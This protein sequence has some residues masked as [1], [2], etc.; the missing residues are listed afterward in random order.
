[1]AKRCMYKVP[2][3]AVSAWVEECLTRGWV[4]FG[5]FARQWVNRTKF[6]RA[7]EFEKR[8]LDVLW[9]VD[10][11]LLKPEPMDEGTY[12]SLEED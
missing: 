11:G 9:Q 1:M 12:Q 10:R 2:S 3:G 6:K 8:A 5:S 7:L 4:P